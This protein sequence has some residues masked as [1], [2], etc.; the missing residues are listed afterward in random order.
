MMWTWNACATCATYCT[1]PAV[2]RSGDAPRR[3]RRVPYGDNVDRGAPAIYV[4]AR[5]LLTFVK[6]LPRALDN[7]F[8]GPY[9]RHADDGPRRGKVSIARHI[10]A[11][12]FQCLLRRRCIPLK[13]ELLVV[14]RRVSDLRV[15]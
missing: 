14:L 11:Y 12:Q 10:V 6:S 8:L 4:V 13:A 2:D 15:R 5:S 7:H 1:V 9:R 3:Y